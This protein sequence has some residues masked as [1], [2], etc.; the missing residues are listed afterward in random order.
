MFPVSLLN[1]P[2]IALN[3]PISGKVLPSASTSTICSVLVEFGQKGMYP[4]LL[5][6]FLIL[7][8]AGLFF[9]DVVAGL[10]LEVAGLGHGEV[11]PHHAVIRKGCEALLLVDQAAHL[12]FEAAE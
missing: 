10:K 5:I 6:H 3:F 7:I 11:H 9:F 8:Q 1:W 2:P 12:G 4:G